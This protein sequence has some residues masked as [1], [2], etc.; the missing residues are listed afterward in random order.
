MTR[1]IRSA[2]DSVRADTMYFSNFQMKLSGSEI[3]FFFF[4]GRQIFQSIICRHYICSKI[5]ARG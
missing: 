2:L 3:F 4:F 1:S 5:V